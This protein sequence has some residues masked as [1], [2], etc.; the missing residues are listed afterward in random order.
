MRFGKTFAYQLAKRMKWRRARA[1]ILGRA[2][3]LGRGL[4]RHV[5]FEGWQFIKPGGLTYEEADKRR[6]SVSALFWTIWDA[7]QARRHQNQERVGTHDNWIAYRTN[8][9]GMARESKG[10]V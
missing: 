10:S 4:K 2:E 6:S 3:R 9:A 8:T 1:D 7:I 5:D